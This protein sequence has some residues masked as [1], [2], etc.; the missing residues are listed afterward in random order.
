[1]TGNTYTDNLCK[2]LWT[3]RV[4][5]LTFKKMIYQ[6]ILEAIG[7]TPMV[8]IN[9]L[10]PNPK[11]IIYAKLEGQ[12]PGGSVKDRIG[13][14]MI[15]AA[16]KSGE[17]TKDKI[18]LEPTSGNTGIG[19]ALVG[20]VKGYKVTLTMSA[21]MSMERKKMLRA[22]G[23]ELVETDPAKGTDGAIMKAREMY[24]EYPEKYWMPYQFSNPNNP[25]AHY[26]GTAEEIIKDLPYVDYFVAGLG[27]SGTLMGAGKRLKEHNPNIKIVGIEPQ[28]GHKI[29]GL[30]NMKE[31]IVPEIFDETKLDK[32]IVVYNE[33]A[34]ET[35]RQLALKEGIFAGMSSGA[36]MFGA[37]E[38][39]RTVNYGNMVV[40]FPDRGEKYLSTALFK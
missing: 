4:F 18:I 29:A 9:S 26:R 40:I 10:N 31:A 11:V 12:N 32:K 39:A 22:L 35:A 38:F 30:K 19:L 5:L 7:H 28:F 14:S 21:G 23:A 8:K 37:L 15:A 20:T 33:Q 34:Y 17:L 24:K 3:K 13:L 25:L 1:M 36:A 16:E 27:T 6:N 2:T